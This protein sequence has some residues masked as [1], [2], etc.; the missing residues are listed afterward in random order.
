M[1]ARRAKARCFTQSSAQ[2][3]YSEVQQELIAQVQNNTKT[4]K[5]N[6]LLRLKRNPTR[7]VQTR[8]LPSMREVKSQARD[9]IWELTHAVTRSLQSFGGY[10]SATLVH[11][12]PFGARPCRR[13]C[14]TAVRKQNPR[15][16]H[17]QRCCP[18]SERST[19]KFRKVVLLRQGSPLM[20][21]SVVVVETQRR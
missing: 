15:A 21:N 7:E 11:H 17:K 8:T 3:R 2:T 10:G 18:I 19:P 14:G 6:N 20:Q 16:A 13:R 1:Q 4:P 12:L 5:G 9:A